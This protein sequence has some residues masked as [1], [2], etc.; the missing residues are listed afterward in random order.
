MW[1]NGAH[2]HG[3]DVGEIDGERVVE[4]RERTGRGWNGDMKSLRLD[5]LWKQGNVRDAGGM[6]TWSH[7]CATET[8]KR[9]NVME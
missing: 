4:T 7:E 9:W 6:V 1:T 8:R 3:W 2:G 5:G